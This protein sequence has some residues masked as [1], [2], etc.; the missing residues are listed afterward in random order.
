MTDK[1][2]FK[3]NGANLVEK[4]ILTRNEIKLKINIKLKNIIFFPLNAFW[5]EEKNCEID[6][7]QVTKIEVCKFVVSKSCF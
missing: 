5:N 6:S 4:K 1:Y 3:L 2:I 7:W